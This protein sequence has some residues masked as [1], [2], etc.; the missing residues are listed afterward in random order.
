MKQCW[1][2]SYGKFEKNVGPFLIF[3]D[4]MFFDPSSHCECYLYFAIS[5]WQNSYPISISS[6]FD[7]LWQTTQSY[8]CYLCYKR[9]QFNSPSLWCGVEGLSKPS[10]VRGLGVLSLKTG[11]GVALGAE[12]NLSRWRFIQNKDCFSSKIKA[13]WKRF[14]KL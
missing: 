5:P 10:F 2:H 11:G 12:V 9:T 6:S 8:H 13:F 14:L 1:P 7:R 4:S 3:S